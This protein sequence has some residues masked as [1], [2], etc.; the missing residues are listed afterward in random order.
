MSVLLCTPIYYFN[1]AF[2]AFRV[3]IGSHQLRA[4]MMTLEYKI[5]FS[6]DAYRHI[7]RRDNKPHLI[8]F[9][10]CAPLDGVD[11]PQSTLA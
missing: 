8:F 6:H 1:T 10:F 3:W 5:L 7:P 9:F 11:L 2:A 4:S